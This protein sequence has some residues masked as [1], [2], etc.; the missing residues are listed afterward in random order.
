MNILEIIGFARK[1]A[2]TGRELA[3]NRPE[4]SR[5][6]PELAG[7]QPEPAGNQP[8]PVGTNRE[9]ARN[10]LEPAG[11]RFLPTQA[12]ESGGIGSLYHESGVCTTD[13]QGRGHIPRARGR[14]RVRGAG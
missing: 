9:L 5:N 4:Q 1:L 6:G 12:L 2:A 13:T 11:N 3:R 7:N 8:E 10:Q 14:H